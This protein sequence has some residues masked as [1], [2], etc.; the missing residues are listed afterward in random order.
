MNSLNQIKGAKNRDAGLQFEQMIDGACIA[1][2]ERGTAK[3]EKTPEPMRIIRPLGNGQYIAVFTKS[4][5]PD[6]KGILSNGKMVVF[7]AK[8]TDTEKMAQSRVTEDQRQSLDEYAAMGATC[9]IVC[10]FSS[11]KAYRIPWGVWDAMK[12]LYGRKYITEADIE[13]FRVKSDLKI[14][15]LNS[16]LMGGIGN[17]REV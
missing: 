12:E 3:I 5:Q 2:A 13:G 1:Y 17:G 4:A 14:W 10:G 7:D 6:Y 11:G 8:Y 16:V 9:F 15:F